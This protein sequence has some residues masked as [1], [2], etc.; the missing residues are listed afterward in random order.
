MGLWPATE[1]MLL[2]AGPIEIKSVTER[3]GAKDQQLWILGCVSLRRSLLSLGLHF[4]SS[5]LRRW[6]SGLQASSRRHKAP[7]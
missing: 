4:P 7:P 6:M 3:A 5:K 2:W 1:E